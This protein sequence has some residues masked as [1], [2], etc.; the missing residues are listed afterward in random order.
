LGVASEEWQ[1]GESVVYA[2]GVTETKMT[3]RQTTGRRG[4]K[5]LLFGVGGLVLAGVAG[6]VGFQAWLPGYVMSKVQDAAAQWGVELSDCALSYERNGLTVTKVTLEH[7]AVNVPAPTSASGTIGHLEVWL[8]EEKPKRVLISAADIAVTGTPDL[9]QWKGHLEGSETIAVTGQR[10]RL[11][12]VTDPGRPPALAISDLQRLSETEDWTGT[13]VLAEIMDGTVRFGDKAHVE[14]RLRSMPANTLV[15]DVDPA[16]SVGHVQLEL[17]DVPFML[18]SGIVFA[19]VPSELAT[20]TATG[21]LKL[22]IPYGLNPGQPKGSFDFTLAGLN[23]PVPRELAG[24]V[25]DTSPHLWGTLNSNRTYKKF[26]APKVNFETGAL[27]MKGKGSVERD[28]IQTHW[29]ATMQGPLP[30]DAIVASAAR[31]HLQGVPLGKELSEAATK[32]S[33]KA[34]KGSVNIM[35]ALDAESTDLAAAKLVK[36]VGIGCG[37]QPLPVPDLG[38]LPEVLLKDL[39]Q[40]KDLPAALGGTTPPPGELPKLPDLKLPKELPKLEIPEFKLPGGKRMKPT[41]DGAKGSDPAKVPQ[42]SGE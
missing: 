20:T 16:N 7:C 28:G 10:N 33:R 24:L 18:F 6:V 11:A 34:L 23:F 22:D 29:Q 37:L 2:L 9:E 13:L 25:Y 32:I 35:V 41:P 38:S 5:A 3:G 15:A 21:S 39:P 42:K 1:W 40:L 36:S 14:L 27:R 19:N 17:S 4:A 26:D 31:V 30:C 12:W 8:E